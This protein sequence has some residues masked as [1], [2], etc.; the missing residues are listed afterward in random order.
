M[1]S[2]VDVQNWVHLRSNP[3]M[4]VSGTAEEVEGAMDVLYS[5][6][7][8]ETKGHVKYLLVSQSSSHHKKRRSQMHVRC[9]AV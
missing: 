4:S 3:V 2:F 6:V 5:M 7:I 1:N 8:E 9:F